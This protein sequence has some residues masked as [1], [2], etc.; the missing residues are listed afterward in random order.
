MTGTMMASWED[1]ET[2]RNIQFAVEYRA[3]NGNVEVLNVTPLKVTIY[4]AKT[5][6]NLRSFGVHTQKGRQ[7]LTSQFKE[8]GQ[9][10]N[11]TE[12]LLAHHA[13]QVVA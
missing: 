8:S 13:A 3:A 7:L 10:L 1:E 4:C 9:M 11:L 2:N 12:E 5:N 6:A